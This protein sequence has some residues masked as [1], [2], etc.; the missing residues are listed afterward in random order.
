ME[1]DAVTTPKT[2]NSIASSLVDWMIRS[3]PAG[4]ITWVNSLPP[5]KT[6][7]SAIVELGTRLVD[8]Q[9]A[10]GFALAVRLGVTRQALERMVKSLDSLVPDKARAIINDSALPEKL[11]IKALT[12]IQP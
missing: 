8:Y 1:N 5:G 6:R 4:T 9:P 12:W 7:E 3:D 2:R 11:K 10:E